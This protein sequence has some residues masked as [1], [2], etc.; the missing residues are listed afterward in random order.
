[1]KLFVKLLELLGLM[2]TSSSSKSSPPPKVL[3]PLQSTANSITQI[4]LQD[5]I[6]SSNKYPERANSPELTS[7]VKIRAGE[8]LSK[9]NQLLQ[10]IEV[11]AIVSSG[12]RPSAVNKNIPNAATK[13]LHMTGGA[14]DLLDPNGEIYSK[15]TPELLRK[16]SLWLEHR[17]HT[18]GWVHLDQ[19]NRKAREVR[20]F[21]P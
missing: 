5:W 1:M 16:Y 7:D 6:T 13:S 15:I 4:T 14:I 20:I 8:L 21:R 11:N 10:E 9:V 19:G 17:D 12:F 3:E 18:K 2:K